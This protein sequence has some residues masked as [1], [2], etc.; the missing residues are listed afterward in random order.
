MAQLYNTRADSGKSD[1]IEGGRQNGG[2]FGPPYS[3]KSVVVS[4]K[5]FREQLSILIINI[6]FCAI[7]FLFIP[8]FCPSSEKTTIEGALII[9]SSNQ[10]PH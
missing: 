10:R 5:I 4:K 6:I 1:P 3:W 2:E 7:D 8:L 9:S